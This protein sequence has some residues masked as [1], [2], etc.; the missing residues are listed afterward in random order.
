MRIEAT[1]PDSR[2]AAVNELADELGLSRSQLVDE[3]LALFLKVVLEVR[4]GR[5]VLTVDP[6]RRA[7]DCELMTP[8]LTNLEWAATSVEL[9]VS[10]QEF[11]AMEGLTREPPEPTAELRKAA[12]EHG[13]WL[14][15][16]SAAA[17]PSDP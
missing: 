5:R 3:A 14:S 1:L 6:A 13:R 2:G 7:P 9:K 10:A 17:E 4:R 12:A 8:T 11:A 16:R 15:R